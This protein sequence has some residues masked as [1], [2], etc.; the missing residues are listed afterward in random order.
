MKKTTPEEQFKDPSRLG[1]KSH[2]R[3]LHVTLALLLSV[4][5]CHRSRTKSSTAPIFADSIA[6]IFVEQDHGTSLHCGNPRKWAALP[7]PISRPFVY[8]HQ[9]RQVSTLFLD[10]H[11][12]VLG[13]SRNRRPSQPVLVD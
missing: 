13:C 4:L 6:L 8:F 7:Q 2:S 9:R 3:S 12:G 5:G 11:L 1:F 10:L